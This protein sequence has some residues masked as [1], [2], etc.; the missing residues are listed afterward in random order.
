MNTR[1]HDLDLVF[2][3]PTR[4][5]SAFYGFF[6]SIRWGWRVGGGSVW[7]REKTPI[8]GLAPLQQLLGK[9]F[10]EVAWGLS[11]LGLKMIWSSTVSKQA[12][13]AAAWELL[14]RYL[15]SVPS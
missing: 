11:H 3:L 13:T 1:V 4:P 10:K 6:N 5:L 7:G 15:L 8:F 9:R 12:W 2:V 14:A